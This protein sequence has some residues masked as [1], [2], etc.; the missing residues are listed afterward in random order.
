[1]A[2]LEEQKQ[3]FADA[4]EGEKRRSD[5]GVFRDGHHPVRRQ[6]N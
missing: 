4:T 5:D 2:V 1:M 6:V 3:I